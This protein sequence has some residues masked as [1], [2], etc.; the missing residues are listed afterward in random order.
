MERKCTHLHS[1]LIPILGETSGFPILDFKYRGSAPLRMSPCLGDTLIRLSTMTSLRR[2]PQQNMSIL[3]P[4]LV[5]ADDFEVCNAGHDGGVRVRVVHGR[6]AAGKCSR[7]PEPA[8]WVAEMLNLCSAFVFGGRISYSHIFFA[9]IN[10]SLSPNLSV[11]VADSWL[12]AYLLLLC[13]TRRNNT[14]RLHVCGDC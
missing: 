11:P 9:E 2:V 1:F 14:W 13:L 5:K 12:N 10:I 4:R 6:L 8:V 7:C 3:G